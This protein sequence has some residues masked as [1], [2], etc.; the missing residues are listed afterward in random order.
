MPTKN[1]V[2][3]QDGE[4]KI[5]VKGVDLTLKWKEINAVSGSL[6]TIKLDELKN[7]DGNDLLVG[8]SGV[9]ITRAD[10]VDGFQY[11]I[12]ASS[13]GFADKIEEGQA[14]VEVVDTDGNDDATIQFWADPN[15]DGVSS[16]I[17]EFDK[18]GHL[19]PDVNEEYDIGKAEK[20]VRH[21]FLS[22]NSLH[23]GTTST[24]DTQWATGGADIYK[25]G[26]ND[27]HQLVWNTNGTENIIATLS[28]GQSLHPIA[29][30]GDYSDLVSKPII[31]SSS[32]DLTSDH[33]AT[34]YT[35]N[36]NANLTAHLSG[37]DTALGTLISDKVTQADIDAAIQGL[38]IKPSV[39]VATTQSLS[40]T[41]SYVNANTQQW[42]EINATGELTID[43][44]VLTNGDR[45]LVKNASAQTQNGIYVVSGI[46][47]ISQVILDRSS[48]LDNSSDF[49]GAFTFVEEGTTNSGNSYVAKNAS[50][51]NSTTVG[52]NTQ[53][54]TQF[55]SAGS[56]TALNDLSDVTYNT[57]ILDIDNLSTLKLNNSG[58]NSRSYITYESDIFGLYGTNTTN[59]NLKPAISLTKNSISNDA[60][61]AT[62]VSSLN[63][64]PFTY[65]KQTALTLQSTVASSADAGSIIDVSFQAV[66]SIYDTRSDSDGVLI[67]MGYNQESDNLPTEGEPSLMIRNT[68]VNLR[69]GPSLNLENYSGSSALVSLTP[70]RVAGK[71]KF[72]ALSGYSTFLKNTAII[73][74]NIIDP[75]SALGTSPEDDFSGDLKFYISVSGSLTEALS[76]SS[77]S[78]FTTDP[79]NGD[80]SPYHTVNVVNHDGANNGLALSGS[81]VTSTAEELN[82]LNV[83]T[84]APS[85]GQVLTY[86]SGSTSTVW[87]DVPSGGIASVSEDSAPRLGGSL[88]TNGNTI[89]INTGTNLIDNYSINRFTGILTIDTTRA[90]NAYVN[91]LNS[92]P[93]SGTTHFSLGKTSGI[94]NGQVLSS[95]RSQTG[96]STTDTDNVIYNSIETTMDD[97]TTGSH[98]GSTRFKV[99]VNGTL[100]EGLKISAVGSNAQV[101]ISNAFN[102]PTFDGSQGQVLSTNGSGQTAWAPVPSPFT[103]LTSNLSTVTLTSANVILNLTHSSTSTSFVRV[104][105][106]AGASDGDMVILTRPS[107]S[108][109]AGTGNFPY[110]SVYY[111]NTKIRDIQI[112]PSK[113]S[114][115]LTF[116][117]SSWTV[118]ISQDTIKAS[119][120]TTENIYKYTFGREIIYANSSAGNTFTLA[121]NHTASDLIEGMHQ[122][123]V[124]R[125]TRTVTITSNDVDI[126]DPSGGGTNALTTNSVTLTSQN[127]IIDIYVFADSSTSNK[128]LINASPAGSSSSTSVSRPSVTT[129]T[130]AGTVPSPSSTDI[131]ETVHLIQPTGAITLT[132]PDISADAN[133]T[134]G[135]KYQLKNISSHTITINPSSG[136]S[137]D[138]S[139]SSRTLNQY[140]N[141]TLIVG[142]NTD[143]YII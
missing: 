132:L 119:N 104:N 124:I 130:A 61:I 101:R 17:W 20:K 87:S 16:K 115:I 93:S 18:D 33:N 80:A 10:D 56:V 58:L 48:D 14:K 109:G 13:T 26:K 106:P 127:G 5:G 117:G 108:D 135:F 100:A 35:G 46:D 69:Q 102:L 96:N 72:R 30:S 138:G 140:D 121:L 21:L 15:N 95:I 27:S 12:S 107:A 28:S 86:S 126:I 66:S 57:G 88:W 78:D 91:I 2:P 64:R 68:N 141:F 7:Q 112:M 45:V 44:V 51:P 24:D 74:S 85:D 1:L 90:S 110:V 139:T 134:T 38:D 129:I 39:R 49:G 114:F 8:G 77:T 111:N 42:Q 60:S 29:T 23:I 36:L 63:L 31:P 70:N 143:W 52:T 43:D 9:T 113:G 123:V 98:D 25:L 34:N 40:A 103:T 6:D 73:E 84:T 131:L 55:N 19:I 67:Q 59:T 122:R 50:S 79:T 22:N 137:I 92:S 133:I 41:F 71:I 32:D 89:N 81:L 3:R 37:I 4:G 136:D 82:V 53:N 128:F 83:H 62:Y 142:T 75:G 76:I 118:P 125:G 47:G 54:W 65:A 97:T 11:T 105:L 116:N 99:A 120:I 94:S